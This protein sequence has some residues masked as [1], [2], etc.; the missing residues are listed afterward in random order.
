[1]GRPNIKGSLML[2]NP[3]AKASLPMVICCLSFLATRKMAMIRPRVAPEPPVLPNASLML[4]QVRGNGHPRVV[5]LVPKYAR[6]ATPC[7]ANITER[8]ALKV[9]GPW[10][11]RIHRNCCATTKIRIVTIFPPRDLNGVWM[12]L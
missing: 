12:L 6:F 2:N 1:M 5:P 4:P 9:F 11:P 3:G 10:I 8:M 7:S